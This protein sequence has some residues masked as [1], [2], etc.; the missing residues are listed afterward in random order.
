MTPSERRRDARYHI[1]RPAKLQ[2]LETGRFIPGAITNVSAS[3]AMLALQNASLM[4]PGQRVRLGV[5]W[6]RQNALIAADSMIEGTVVR[7]AGFGKHQHV[8]LSFDHQVELAQT[9]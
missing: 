2:C 9:A 4:V 1:D 3:G 7:A 6:T 8:A 5:A